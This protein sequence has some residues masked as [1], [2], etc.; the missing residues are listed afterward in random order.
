MKFGASVTGCICGVTARDM[1]LRGEGAVQGTTACTSSL[2]EI[3][4]RINKHDAKAIGASYV[5]TA[6]LMPPTRQ[7][8]SGPA[9][10]ESS[11]PDFS[12]TV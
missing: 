2:M 4:G 3:N 10:I 5:A 6:K 8:A 1:D 9:E 12:R 11:L 7:V